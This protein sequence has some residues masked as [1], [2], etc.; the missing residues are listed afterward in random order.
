MTNSTHIPKHENLCVMDT[1]NGDE[2]GMKTRETGKQNLELVAGIHSK[3]CSAC[4]QVKNGNVFASR[5]IFDSFTY[6]KVS[7]NAT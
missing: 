2:F 7:Q 4:E 3:A 6:K 1:Q 5:Q